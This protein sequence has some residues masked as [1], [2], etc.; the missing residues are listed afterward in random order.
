MGQSVTL[1]CFVLADP[2][3]YHVFWQIPESSGQYVTLNLDGDKYTP[4]SVDSPSL[5]IHDTHI[6]DSGTYRCGATNVVGTSY[7]YDCTLKVL[8]G[9]Y[10]EYSSR[11]YMS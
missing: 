8:G 10:I 7:S 3:V 9:M 2:G 1:D 5:T 11:L 6:S 4:L